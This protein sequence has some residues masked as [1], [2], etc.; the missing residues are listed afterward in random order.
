MPPK[1][2]PAEQAAINQF[3]AEVRRLREFADVSQRE[4]GELT[5][6]SKQQ[7]GSIER[8]E[9]R[10]SKF[11]AQEADRALNG[12]GRLLDLWPGAKRAQPWWFQKYVDIEAKAQVIQEFQPQAVPGLLQTQDYAADVLGA[13]FPPVS[14]EEQERLLTSRM[15]RQEILG[16]D[17]PPLVHFVIE[18]GALR[19]SVGNRTVMNGQ[20]EHLIERAQ[21]RHIQIQVMPFNRG[22]HGALNGAFITL[23]MTLL[24]CLV[25]AEVPE[26]GHIIAD[27]DVV[28]LCLERFGALRGLALSPAES[29]E[30]IASLKE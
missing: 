10:P 19:R 22:S 7:V 9:R 30:F 27:L 4:L 5:K 20:L 25:Y 17:N 12:H 29:I 6:T 15:E 26:N 1:T 14:L 11:F 2:T 28:A 16:R 24:E 18:E 3:G 8:G 21:Q 23:R 13:S